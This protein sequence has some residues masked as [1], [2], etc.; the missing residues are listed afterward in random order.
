MHGLDMSVLLHRAL[1]ARV[2]RLSELAARDGWE[3]DPEALRQV[4]IAS[5]RARAALGLVRQDCYPDL[6]RHRRT[7]RRLTRALGLT[8]DLDARIA[9]LAGLAGRIPGMA[10]GA[11]LEHLLEGLGRSRSRAAARMG[12]D[13]PRKGL[14]RLPELLEVPSLPDPF[15]P[16][17]LAGDAWTALDPMLEAAFSPLP[18]LRGR[19]DAGAMHRVRIRFKRAR[20]ALEVLAPAWAAPPEAAL[21]GLKALQGALGA[22]HDLA[23]LEAALQSEHEGLAGRGRATLAKG[24]LEVLAC[25][26]E[27]RLDAFGRFLAAEAA[28]PFPPLR[29]A[30]RAGLDLPP[31]ETP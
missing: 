15:A 9:F 28:L 31:E 17:S 30:L 22:H 23:T 4:R 2:A 8:R 14:R 24:L 19:E 3:E 18:G 10:T 12:R 5:R 26:G 27:A 6:R 16:S 1:E 7:L 20:Y 11:A 21:A 25:V 29:A 13:L